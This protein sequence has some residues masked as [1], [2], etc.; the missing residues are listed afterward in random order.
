MV[1]TGTGVTSKLS[2]LQVLVEQVVVHVDVLGADIQV[3][4][5]VGIA[6]ILAHAARQVLQVLLLHEVGHLRVVALVVVRMRGVLVDVDR[7]GEQALLRVQ[8]DGHRLQFGHLQLGTVQLVHVLEGH[9]AAALRHILDHF[10]AVLPGAVRQALELAMEA[11]T[12]LHVAVELGRE[13]HVL[14]GGLEQA[15]GKLVQLVRGQ[16]E[17]RNGRIA[18]LQ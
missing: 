15:V 17:L 5:V 8:G 16:L 12:I 9:G 18:V 3:L 1:G 2:L 13:Q 4:Q 14:V 7:L 6:S 10:D 11:G